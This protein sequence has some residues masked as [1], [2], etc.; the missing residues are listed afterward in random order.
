MCVVKHTHNTHAHAL[1]DADCVSS[2]QTA[3]SQ[4]VNR[5]AVPAIFQQHYSDSVSTVSA[6]IVPRAFIANR[7]GDI[8]LVDGAH[9][10]RGKINCLRGYILVQ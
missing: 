7:E 8:T 5:T 10:K 3:S 1:F 6:H 9:C 4:Q 2:A